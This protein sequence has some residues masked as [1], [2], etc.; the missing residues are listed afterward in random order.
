MTLLIGEGGSGI[1]RGGPVTQEGKEMVRWNAT[2]HG[3]RSPAPVVPGVE[4]NEDWEEH[5]EGILESL[6]PEGHLEYV[7]AERVALL[8]WRL[9]RVTRYETETI[10]LSQEKVEDDL[11]DKRRFGSYLLG[12]N[13]PQDVRGAVQDT[14]RAER[15]IK[16]FPKLPNDKRLSGPD[17]AGILDLVWGQT[18]EEVQAEEVHLPEEIPDW[19]G[20]EGDMAEWDGWTVSLVR[21]CISAIA[22]VA[23]ED[24][25]ELIEAAT[26]RARLDIITAKSAAERVER[27]LATMSRERLLPDEKT[28]EKVARYEAHLSRLFHKALHELEALQIRRAGGTA[29]LARLDVDGLAGS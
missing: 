25:E 11:A 5:R 17:A 1:A 19:A 28:L 14:L 4:R 21:D 29:P 13:H 23:G 26:E 18:D 15:L 10:V 22:A 8:S 3:I 24:Q 6:S 9:H 7:L 16:R 27:D 12:P 20:L 2:R